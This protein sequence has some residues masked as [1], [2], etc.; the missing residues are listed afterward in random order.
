MRYVIEGAIVTDSPYVYYCYR[1][2]IN[3]KSLFSQL[4]E[5]VLEHTTVQS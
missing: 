2:Y 3:M 1:N 4:N 5:E